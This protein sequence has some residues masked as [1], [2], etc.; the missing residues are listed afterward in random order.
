MASAITT[1]LLPYT[2]TTRLNSLLAVRDGRLDG[3]VKHLYRPYKQQAPKQ[4]HKSLAP[5]LRHSCLMS[6]KRGWTPR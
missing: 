3:A 5:L 6:N 2:D 1:A 4:Q